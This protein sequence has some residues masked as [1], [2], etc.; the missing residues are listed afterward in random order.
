VASPVGKP[1]E[2]EEW[3]RLAWNCCTVV[4]D[5]PT[6]ANARSLRKTIEPSSVTPRGR[7]HVDDVRMMEPVTAS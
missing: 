3:P 4:P 1:I 6:R 2:L 5:G 7:S